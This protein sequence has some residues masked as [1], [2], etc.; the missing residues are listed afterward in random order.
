M[1]YYQLEKLISHID[2]VYRILTQ[3]KFVLV[4]IAVF[5]TLHT[6]FDTWISRK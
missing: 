2:D 1:E 6:W 5:Y 3:I 4:Y